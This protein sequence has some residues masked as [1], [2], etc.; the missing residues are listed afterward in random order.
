MDFLAI[1]NILRLQA[2]ISSSINSNI[3]VADITVS[4]YKILV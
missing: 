3:I 1:Q 2:Y 4:A